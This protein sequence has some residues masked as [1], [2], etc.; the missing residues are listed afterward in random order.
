[1]VFCRGC[2]KQL[3]ETALTCPGCG[4]PQTDESTTKTR[5]DGPLWR[6]ILTL[7]IGILAVCPFV[8]GPRLDHDTTVG[9]AMFGVGDLIFGGWTLSQQKHGRWLAIGGVALSVIALLAL[10]G[11]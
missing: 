11:R 6:P 3:H 5:E 8:D 7:V 10:L 4:A 1:M 9:V 2:G